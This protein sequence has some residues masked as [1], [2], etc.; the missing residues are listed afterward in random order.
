MTRTDLQNIA[1]RI[2]KVL[3]LHSDKEWNYS[4]ITLQVKLLSELNSPYVL[5]CDFL[6]MDSKD[7]K[8]GYNS[9]VDETS[10]GDRHSNELG[11]LEIISLRINKALV[12][13]AAI[14]PWGSQRPFIRITKKE[15]LTESSVTSALWYEVQEVTGEDFDS[16]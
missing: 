6:D 11:I 15:T 2:N 1:D 8:L 4:R 13:S 3:K 9:L 7:G 10:W 16:R 14:A 12:E 5:T